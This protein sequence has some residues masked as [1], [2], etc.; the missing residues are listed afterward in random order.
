MWPFKKKSPNITKEGL[1]K[2]SFCGKTQRSVK[3]L[4]AGPG[5]Y[6]CDECAMLCEEILNEEDLLELPEEI[7]ADF[8]APTIP[9]NKNVLSTVSRIAAVDET[10]AWAVMHRLL[11]GALEL[12]RPGWLEVAEKGLYVDRISTPEGDVV[13]CPT[14]TA[15]AIESGRAVLC[16]GRACARYAGCG[17]GSTPP[18]LVDKS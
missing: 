5:V 11:V 14:L 9:V 10:E 6:I 12:E 7:R 15:G 3:K 1:L 8:A 2:C 16:I 18:T 13:V 17:T 4:I